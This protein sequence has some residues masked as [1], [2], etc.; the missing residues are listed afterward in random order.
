MIGCT[1][2]K[3]VVTGSKPNGVY[4]NCVITMVPINKK[5]IRLAKDSVDGVLVKCGAYNI[6]DTLILDRNHFTNY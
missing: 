4:N 3:F 2:A 5:A 1:S 6:G